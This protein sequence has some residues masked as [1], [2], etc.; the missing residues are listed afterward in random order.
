MKWGL[1]ERLLEGPCE[2]AKTE[3]AR[4]C[5]RGLGLSQETPATRTTGMKRWVWRGAMSSKA[6][7]TESGEGG[8]RGNRRPPGPSY[9]RKETSASRFAPAG[10]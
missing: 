4:P 10:A 9:A 3:N 5:V 6:S 2:L 1:M 7:K 8:D